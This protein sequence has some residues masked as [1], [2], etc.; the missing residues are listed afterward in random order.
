MVQLQDEINFKRIDDT[1]FCHVSGIPL[2]P[3]PQRIYFT[4]PWVNL[5]HHPETG[6]NVATVELRQ[7]LFENGYYTFVVNAK[8]ASGISPVI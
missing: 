4:E 1:S 5:Y 7:D 2:Y 3:E 6:S 8:D